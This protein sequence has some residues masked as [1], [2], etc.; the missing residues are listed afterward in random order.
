[1]QAGG[2]PHLRRRDALQRDLTDEP[3]RLENRSTKPPARYT[4]G[5]KSVAN[6]SLGKEELHGPQGSS[7]RTRNPGP[8]GRRPYE[9]LP[10]HASCEEGGRADVDPEPPG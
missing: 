6:S 4:T 7:G 9:D 3:G 5:V 2:G 10:L 1:M 8:E